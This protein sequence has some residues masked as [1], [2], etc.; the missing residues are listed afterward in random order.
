MHGSF[1][2]RQEILRNIKKMKTTKNTYFYIEEFLIYDSESLWWKRRAYQENQQD[3]AIEE[4]KKLK[5]ETDRG[6]VRLI[7]EDHTFRSEELTVE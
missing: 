5:R 1:L 4:L 2:W 6:K 3:E 7:R